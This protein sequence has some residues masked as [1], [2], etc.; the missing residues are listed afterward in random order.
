MR[1]YVSLGAAMM[2]GAVLG[3]ENYATTLASARTVSK[4]I[5]A[6]QIAEPTHLERPVML[7]P[8]RDS[9]GDVEAERASNRS[10]PLDF[11]ASRDSFRSQTRRR[12]VKNR[13]RSQRSI[14]R[15]ESTSPKVKQHWFCGGRLFFQY[16]AYFQC[17]DSSDGYWKQCWSLN[18]GN[19]NYKCYDHT[20][21]KW[22][23]PN[24]NERDFTPDRSHLTSIGTD[25]RLYTSPSRKVQGELSRTPSVLDAH[26]SVYSRDDRYPDEVRAASYYDD[27]Y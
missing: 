22:E 12:H 27:D 26:T 24:W 19:G 23:W 7:H 13:S 11:L 21:G 6:V 2:M 18:V 1:K 4:A 17:F 20:N 25:G 10:Y 16:G 8:R 5:Q 3:R 14:Q 9:V 15:K